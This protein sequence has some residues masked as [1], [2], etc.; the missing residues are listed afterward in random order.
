[1]RYMHYDINNTR[2]AIEK[3]TGKH[4]S[5]LLSFVKWCWKQC[6]CH[7]LGLFGG[8][9]LFYCVIVILMCHVS[10]SVS[11]RSPLARPFSVF[12]CVSLL[13]QPLC[14]CWPLLFIVSSVLPFCFLCCL[15]L[16]FYSCFHAF[17]SRFL[18]LFLFVLCFALRLVLSCCLPFIAS[19]LDLAFWMLSFY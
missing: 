14:Q 16:S 6:K 7:G 18:V 2:S 12:T 19:I 17:S 8:Y 13:H 3:T 9:F 4:Y 15:V 1:M 5:P 10:L 11:S